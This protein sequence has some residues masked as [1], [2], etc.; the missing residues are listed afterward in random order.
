M[1]ETIA[2][3]I[4][5]ILTFIPV[6]CSWQLQHL[7]YRLTANIFSWSF[8]NLDQGWGTYLLSRAAWIVHHRWHATK[9][10]NNSTF[11]WLW[12]RFTSFNFLSKYLLITE[13]RSE[14]MLYSY[15][16]NENSDA[17][18]IQCSRWPQVPHPWSGSVLR[19]R[20]AAAHRCDATRCLLCRGIILSENMSITVRN[21][22][23][24]LIFALHLHCFCDV[25]FKVFTNA[26]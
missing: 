5:Y 3:V 24:C 17:Y 23:P 7:Q 14:A 11:F 1:I 15:L 9:S 8:K 19:N 22:N 10:I 20:S 12:R 4:K 16:G 26:W 21:S 18:H 2:S 13:L 25:R 6:S